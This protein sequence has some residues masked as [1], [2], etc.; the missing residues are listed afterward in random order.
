MK[1]LAAV[2]LVVASVMSAIAGESPNKGFV[3]YRVTGSE[4]YKVVYKGES[5]GL[6]KLNVYNDKNA[7]V[8]SE[9][10]V[11]TTGFI[12]PLNFV[13]LQVGEYTFEL[14]D[15]QG[16]LM[17][18]VTYANTAAPKQ[19]A[20]HIS[21]LQSEKSKY[22]VAINDASVNQVEVSIYDANDNLVHKE[23]KKLEGK[24]AQVYT[25]KNA[26]G[27]IRIEVTAKNAAPVVA[28]F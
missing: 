8:Y 15:A 25:V 24:F 23:V 26:P 5:H 9:S 6:V 27:R 3:V 20:I 11:A 19:A 12:R 13:G 7:L 28:V 14:V 1:N 18:K 16:K 21:K 10:F 4:V 22:M 2:V 17:E